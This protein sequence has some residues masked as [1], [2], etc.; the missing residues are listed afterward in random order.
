MAIAAEP[1]QLN[2][3][4]AVSLELSAVTRSGSSTIG[5][6][7]VRQMNR[8][9]GQPQR[10]GKVSA[11]VTAIPPWVIGAEAEVFIQ[12]EAAPVLAE[13]HQ[14]RF[15]PSLELR[16]KRPVERFHRSAGRQTDWPTLRFRPLEP[17]MEM[18]RQMASKGLG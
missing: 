1:Q 4:A 7:A 3:N 17:A 6:D 15:R 13:L 9:I 11:H 10:A 14:L 16:H 12:V 5:S 2:T 18:L 8:G